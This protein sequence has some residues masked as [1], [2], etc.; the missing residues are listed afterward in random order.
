MNIIFDL[1]GT[2][3]NK[4]ASFSKALSTHFSLGLRGDNY[5]R[6][7]KSMQLQKWT[8]AQEMAKSFLEEFEIEQTEKNLS[9]I[10]SA[11]ETTVSYSAPF[12]EMRRLLENLKENNRLFLLSNSTCFEGE[13]L[14][15]WGFA[16]LFEKKY[17]SFETGHLKPYK[18]SYKYVLED[19]GVKAKECL[20]VDDNVHNCIAAKKLGMKTHL[21]IS[22]ADFER[23]LEENKLLYE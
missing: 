17:F 18:E 8:T 19:I 12:S 9:F 5:K 6:F 16:E 7:E 1:W 2:L 15:K 22:V 23:F 10:V 14:E 21:F 4:N 11:Q 20:F 3:G 13:V